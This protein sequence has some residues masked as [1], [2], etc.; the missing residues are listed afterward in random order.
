MVW[1]GAL[2][3]R[4]VSDPDGIDLRLLERESCRLACAASSWYQ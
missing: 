3:F 4:P 2:T 1:W